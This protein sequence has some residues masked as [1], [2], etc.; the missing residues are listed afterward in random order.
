MIAKKL[1]IPYHEPDL[2]ANVE[3]TLVLLEGDGVEYMWHDGHISKGT[4]Q[5]DITPWVE[6]DCDVM[7]DDVSMEDVVNSYLQELLVQ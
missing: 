4:L 2:Q 1:V 5:R 6:W 3:G 7:S